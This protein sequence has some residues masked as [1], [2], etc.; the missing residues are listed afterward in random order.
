MSRGIDPNVLDPSRCHAHPDVPPTW[1]S[2]GALTAYAADVR[3]AIAKAL[4]EGVAAGGKAA[5]HGGVAMWLVCMAL[6]H[7]RMHQETLEYMLAQQVPASCRKFPTCSNNR[8]SFQ[9]APEGP[10]GHAGAAGGL[11]YSRVMGS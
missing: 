8:Q 11:C 3:T 6:E 5:V 9:H 2:R 7:E 10:G 4:D 1:P